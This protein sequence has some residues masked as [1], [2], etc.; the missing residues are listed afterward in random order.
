M[1]LTLSPDDNFKNSGKQRDQVD[2]FST[3][4]SGLL[5]KPNTNVALHSA[6]WKV[7]QG[8]TIPSGQ[9][10]ITVM[11]H[12]FNISIVGQTFQE[13]PTGSS[14]TAGSLCAKY[15]NDAINEELRLGATN[16]YSGNADNSLLYP[17][18]FRFGSSE[19]T[20]HSTLWE[21]DN[22]GRDFVFE[23]KYNAD[24]D[25]DT[26]SNV[27][28]SGTNASQNFN[29]NAYTK[30]IANDLELTP[31][32]GVYRYRLR[33]ATAKNTNAWNDSGFCAFGSAFCTDG[34]S[35]G[36]KGKHGELVFKWS[37]VNGVNVGMVGFAKKTFDPLRS[38]VQKAIV[39]SIQLTTGSPPVFR[40]LRPDG[41]VSALT[42]TST[43]DDVSHN[44]YFR[45]R[46]ESSTT[47]DEVFTYARSPDGNS[48]TDISFNDSVSDRYSSNQMDTEE[49]MPFFKPNTAYDASNIYGVDNMECTIV[50]SKSHFSG[51]GYKWEWSNFPNEIRFNPDTLSSVFDIKS[52][53]SFSGAGKSDGGVVN[54]VNTTTSGVYV[55]LPTLGIKSITSA[56]ERNVIGMLPIGEMSDGTNGM[57]SINGLQFNQV[58]NLIYLD[59]NNQDEREHNQIRVQLLDHNGN[60]LTNI[61]DVSINLCV[62]P[63]SM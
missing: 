32:S 37:D 49:I 8:I 18:L 1:F 62:K 13:P 52:F 40:E 58:Y 11:G 24:N 54:N 60:F 28:V 6:S 44:D 35:T 45:I 29:S 5:L 15:L 59:M 43:P 33:P 48:F 56:V 53:D 10:Q 26:N 41:T 2:F 55:N 9:M 63:S 25:F 23:M 39:A 61:T 57:G 22:T 30:V 7:I 14:D 36:G 20:N 46:M 50:P 31:G 19:G 4:P 12:T 27:M 42:P 3:I 17:A 34:L 51:S 21:W 47:G 38:Q 16:W